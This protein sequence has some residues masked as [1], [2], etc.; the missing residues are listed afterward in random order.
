MCDKKFERK[1]DRYLQFYYHIL[2]TLFG[3]IVIY[4]MEGV[5]IIYFSSFIFGLLILCIRDYF[6][7]WRD[8][9]VKIEFYDDKIDVVKR[10]ERKT[11][12]IGE[13]YL[14]ESEKLFGG[15]DYIIS[16]NNLEWIG[17]LRSGYW[18]IDR[19]LKFARKK[20]IKIREPFSLFK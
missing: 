6:T 19:I 1:R 10:S 18:D 4:I 16:K 11:Y 15:Y 2:F 17:E 3:L 14:E 13:I 5:D 12:S 8:Q 20:G 9:V 7:Y